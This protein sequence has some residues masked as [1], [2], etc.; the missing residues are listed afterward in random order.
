MGWWSPGDAVR[1]RWAIVSRKFRDFRPGGFIVRIVRTR[2][3]TEVEVSIGQWVTAIRLRLTM[4]G[5]IVRRGEQVA[6]GGLVWLTMLSMVSFC[7]ER[8]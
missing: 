6:W 4:L 1:V 8:G 2:N 5:G 3:T 7:P